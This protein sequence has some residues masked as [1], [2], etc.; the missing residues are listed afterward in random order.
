MKKFLVAIVLLFIIYK[1]NGQVL[2]SVIYD[3]DGLTLGDT[4]L[5]DEDFRQGALTYKVAANPSTPGDMLGDRVLQLNLNWNSG[6]GSFGQRINKF[7]EINPS[8]DIFN[9][10]FYNPAA[11]AQ[12][13]VFDVILVED[14]NENNSYDNDDAWTKT[15][16]I[17]AGGGWQ[18]ISVPINQFKDSN[19]DGNGVFDA[20]FTGKKGMLLQIELVF[21]KAD[22]AQSNPAFFIDMI[23]FS[24]GS[25]PHGATI[26]DLPAK[27]TGSECA[28]GA[29]QPAN[30]GEQ[31]MVPDNIQN[32]FPPQTDKKIKYVNW[33]IQFATD[34]STKAK[35]LPGNEVQI[36]LNNGYIPVIT[37]EPMFKGYD[38]LDPVQPRLSNIINGDYNTYIDAFAD[39]LKSYND[40]IIIRLMHEFEGD[41]YSWSLVHN[42]KD[43]EQ[44]I[45]AYRKVV[46]RVR[47]RGAAKVK[48]MWCLNG[49]YFP[50]QAYNW[51]VPAYPGDAYV[52]IVAADI[53]N[54]H[55]PLPVPSWKSFRSKAAETYYYLTTYF[56]QKPMFICELGC[57]E[58]YDSEN[59]GSETK[60]EWI[61]R[62][63]KEMQSNFKKVK[64]L[65]FFSAL[66]VFDWRINSSPETLRAI[67]DNVW[68]DGYYFK[69]GNTTGIRNE[70][71]SNNVFEIHVLQNQP[72]RSLAI[73]I[74]TRRATPVQADM[75]LFNLAGQKIASI[76]HLCLNGQL[77]ASFS[78]ENLPA[79]IYVVR[80][81][82][83]DRVL[84]KKV[85]LQ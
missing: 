45:T 75:E 3:F 78:T 38:R 42:N 62:M 83:A 28:L 14:D 11:N 37:W 60:P 54:N 44:Y 33:F 56:P 12:S 30:D 61:A 43:P 63:D 31:Y 49:D 58:R 18:L 2:K 67:R 72:D 17:P 1:S 27:N 35:D 19:T 69:R 80:V 15:L 59:T 74:N 34:G 40:T 10:Y 55:T 81:M 50:R 47:A 22:A 46:D 6:Q 23:C 36:L 79:G 32:L 65:L 9:C 4:D 41:W 13:A 76:N 8:G 66:V 70:D 29:F 77:S 26:L 82:L 25:L 71:S 52:D 51:V 39:K 20:A 53:Y 5:P 57:R 64:A 7:I 85:V 21:R 24:D 48:W 73:Q 16:T 84:N 68:N